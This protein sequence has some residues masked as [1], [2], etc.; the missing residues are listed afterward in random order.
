MSFSK[1]KDRASNGTEG[2]TTFRGNFG[3]ESV[4]IKLFCILLRQNQ[5][6]VKQW[7]KIPDN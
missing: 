7:I 5:G 6:K 4:L 2:C 1:T 3:G